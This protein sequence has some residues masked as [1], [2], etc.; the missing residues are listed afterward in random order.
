MAYEPRTSVTEGVSEW[1]SSRIGGILVPIA[2]TLLAF[3]IG[4]LVV[5]ITGSNPI[6]AYKAIFAGTVSTGSS[7]GS[8]ARRASRPRTT[9]SRR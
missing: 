8:P 4:G 7:H 5:L 6:T 9:S 1:F 3:L 2:A